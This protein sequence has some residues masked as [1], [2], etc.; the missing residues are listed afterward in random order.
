MAANDN[1]RVTPLRH[2]RAIALLPFLNTVVIPGTL[3]T[4]FSPTPPLRSSVAAV[5]TILAASALLAAGVALVTHSIHLFVRLGRGTL[6]PWD[7]TRELVCGGAYNYSRN[8]MKL[9][10]FLVLGGEVLLTWSTALAAWFFC[11]AVAN[12]IYIRA[13]EEPRLE[14]RFGARY[15][16]YCARVPRWWPRL[17]AMRRRPTEVS[18][19]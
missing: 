17:R 10:L 11:F 13:H 1:G 3:L 14:A 6:A 15:R 16:E 2:I 7:P 19:T 8:P 5:A 4:A 18:A 9:G 12:V